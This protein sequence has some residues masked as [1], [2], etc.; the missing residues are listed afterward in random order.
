MA[1]AHCRCRAARLC[2]CAPVVQQLRGE[3]EG[4]GAL[5]AGKQALACV[6]ALVLQQDREAAEGLGALATGEGP[7]TRVHTRCCARCK[8][9]TKALLQSGQA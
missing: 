5:S 9:R 8:G 1:L 6:Y 3:A 2:V 4:L 7:L